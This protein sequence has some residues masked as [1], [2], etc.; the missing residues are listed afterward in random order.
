L[1]R[2]GELAAAREAGIKESFGFKNMIASYFPD[3]ATIVMEQQYLVKATGHEDLTKDFVRLQSKE[4]YYTAPSYFTLNGVLYF[5]TITHGLGELLRYADRNAMAHGREVRLPFLSHDLVEF[6]FSLPATF[7]IRKGRTK[8]LLRESMKSRLPSAIINR[9]DKIGFEPP[10]Q[11]WME[12]PAV[13]T[14]ILEAKRIL[15]EEKV[16]KPSVLNKE[17]NPHTAHAAN[18]FDW[19]YLSSAFLFK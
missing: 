18:P 11:N 9:T 8:W 13:K 1:R 17:I 3:F 16:L 12:T 2:S 14:A 10:Q 4:A 6:V 15:V 19:R 7:K 5:N